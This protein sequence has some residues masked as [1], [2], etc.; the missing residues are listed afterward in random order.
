MPDYSWPNVSMLEGCGE[1]PLHPPSVAGTFY[2][3]SRMSALGSKPEVS[4]LPRRVCFTPDNRHQWSSLACP[5]VPT[6]D[7][8]N[9]RGRRLRRPYRTPSS[10]IARA[11]SCA[12]SW[13]PVCAIL[14][15]FVA[16]ISVRG[17]SRS[18][19]QRVCN[20]CSYA[21]MMQLTSFGP[22]PKADFSNRR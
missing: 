13:T 22:S 5:K 15:I 3:G 14:M 18:L 16:I 17:S 1:M 19:T 7:I 9:E 4:G 8:R 21:S 2:F 12:G 6:G 10:L 20:A 11:E